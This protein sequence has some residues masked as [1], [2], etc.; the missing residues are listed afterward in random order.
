[1]II[2]AVRALC[3]LLC[4]LLTFA[5]ASDFLTSLSIPKEL[6][7]DANAIVRLNETNILLESY[8]EMV[9]SKKRIITIFNSKGIKHAQGVVHY[10]ENIKIRD[11]EANIYDAFGKKLKRIKEKDFRDVSAVDGATLYS[12]SRVKYLDYTP[13]QY[14]YTVELIYEFRTN[15][16][17]FIPWFYPI[18]GYNLSIEKSIYEIENPTGLQLRYKEF[19][20]DS[21]QIT[22]ETE[23]DNFKYILSN[24][25]ATESESHSPLLSQITPKVMFASNKFHLEGVDAEVDSWETYGKWMYDNLL[26]NRQDLP[27]ETINEVKN[28]IKD[29]TTVTDKAKAIYKYVQGKTRYISVQVGIGGWKPFEAAEVDRLSYGDCKGLTNYTLALLKAVGIESFYTVVF[30][31]DSQKDITTDFASIQGNHVILKI[32]SPEE[33]IWLECTSQ[34]LPFGFI[35]DFTD[36][37]DVLVVTPDGGF[38]EHTKKYGFDKSR[39]I[40]NSECFLLEDGGL[41]IKTEITSEG[42]QY[43]NKYYLA[44][45]KD[46]DI[47]KAYKNRWSFINGLKIEHY[48]I[49]NDKEAVR[50]TEMIEMSTP[51][52]SNLVGDRMLLVLNTI[53]RHG[54][55]PNRYRNRNLPLVIKRGFTDR[56]E[57][58]I[59]LPKSYTIES[60]PNNQVIETQFGSYMSQIIKLDEKTILYK[61][62]FIVK[63]GEYSKDDYKAFRSFHK[64]VTKFDNAKIALIKTTKKN[65]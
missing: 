45:A 40:S 2:K 7:K 38:I 56:D 37:R 17:A 55:L 25:V 26:A 58:K 8:D 12:D 33:T 32:P 21:Y 9:I 6:L 65:E 1:M 20:L 18:Q 3:F 54:Y 52:Y 63:D 64:Q 5:Q 49:K 44:Y 10:D 14:P 47:D 42:I 59:H 19:N 23:G 51:S 35:G 4:P 15:N 34:K 36:N 28:L 57:I 27:N 48:D 16:T 46:R 22:K 62:E 39:Q 53:N 31:G 30:A 60:L 61:R 11:L 41:K 29:K 50:F 24:A 13:I 43:D